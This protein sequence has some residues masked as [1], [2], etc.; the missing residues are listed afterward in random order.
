M[1]LSKPTRVWVTGLVEV[2]DSM[3]QV[4]MCRQ[5]LKD[6]IPGG[7]MACSP[8]TEVAQ[9]SGHGTLCLR[10]YL[11]YTAPNREPDPGCQSLAWNL[12]QKRHRAMLFS[13]WISLQNEK[14]KNN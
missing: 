14:K 10:I 7:L 11:Q 3:M 5:L 9:G 12:S 2:G 8:S 1:R 6:S 4:I 13:S